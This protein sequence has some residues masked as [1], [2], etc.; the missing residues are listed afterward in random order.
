MKLP[1]LKKPLNGYDVWIGRLLIR[2]NIARS[3]IWSE[4]THRITRQVDHL[5]SV[6]KVT[7]MIIN[8][9]KKFVRLS[10]IQ[11]II[12]PLKIMIGMT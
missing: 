9:Q 3:L 1:P 4:Q 11:I 10:A 2:F 8:D 6:G 12:G 5:L 7:R